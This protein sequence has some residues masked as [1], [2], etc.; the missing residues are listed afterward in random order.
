MG[1]AKNMDLMGLFKA[2]DEITPD[3]KDP[4]QE[5]VNKFEIDQNLNSII[6]L[7]GGKL[8]LEDCMLSLNFIVKT[9]V[10]ILPALVVNEG[11]EAIVN[12]C[13]IKGN[14]NHLTVGIMCRN[15][16][17]VLKET[18]IHNHK[19]GGVLIQ[20][21][22]HNIIKIANCKIVFNDIVGVHL[23]GEDSSPNLENNRIENNNGPGIKVGI[24]TKAKIVKNTIKLNQDGI[25]VMS[26]DPHIFKN[27]IEKNYQNA[28]FVCTHDDI[29]CDGLMEKNEISA[30][31][32]NGIHVTGFNNFPRI[33][34]NT[35][36][37][38]NKLAGIRVDNGA[39]CS[40][41]RNSVSKNLGQ[42]ILIV[43]TAS[44]H[45]EKN[46]V[47]ENIKANIA[48]G[49]QNSTNTT[50]IDNRIEF[51]RC[52]GIF[53]ISGGE[54]Y[55]HRNQISENNEGLVSITS[56]PDIRGNTI[57]KNKSNGI[58]LL[59]DSRAKM[60]NNTLQGNDGI[61]LYIRDKSHGQICNN[62]LTDNE[63][64]LVIER[65][66]EALEQ[67]L[68]DNQVEGDARIPQNFLCNVF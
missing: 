46:S 11:A 34:G 2:N 49:G 17:L 6:L 10:A 43:E 25:H 29:R 61:G 51:G 24:A 21:K 16:N 50:V 28:I 22:E 8:Y 36:I 59:K 41:L 52:E 53:L 55:I 27:K 67:I 15:G 68:R 64:D 57:T 39:H 4:Y 44:A 56:V 66:H 62:L 35:F 12:K 7:N 37:Q 26:A 40:I 14:K 33:I 32:R 9:H 45:I 65:K 3:T 1:E 47:F 54:C 48:L 63:I 18:K 30:N 19:A 23:V 20:A 5:L 31:K 13:E 38:Y 60:F 58:M 42:G